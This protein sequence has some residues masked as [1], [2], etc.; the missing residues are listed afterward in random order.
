MSI[1]NAPR[2]PVRAAFGYVDFYLQCGHRWI[3][4]AAIRAAIKLPHG[5]TLRS[6]VLSTEAWKAGL[7]ARGLVVRAKGKGQ[8]GIGLPPKDA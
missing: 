2:G 3:P 5:A 6:A 4:Y 1:P 8:H 7:A